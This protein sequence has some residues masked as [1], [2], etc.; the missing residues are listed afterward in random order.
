MLSAW[1]YWYNCAASKKNFD[2]DEKAK[3]AIGTAA[4]M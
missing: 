3:A 4:L 1:H 2:F